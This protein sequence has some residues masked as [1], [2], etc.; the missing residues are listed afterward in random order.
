MASASS[1]SA[2]TSRTK[3]NNKV[4]FIAAAPIILLIMTMFT[5]RFALPSEEIP[6]APRLRHAPLPPAIIADAATQKAIQATASGQI[7]AIGRDDF[8]AALTFAVPEFAAQTNPTKFGQ[9][10]RQGFAPLH[11]AKHI[12]MQKAQ[13]FGGKTETSANIAVTVQDASGQKQGYR[14]S[15]QKSGDKWLITGCAPT[16][17][18]SSPSRVSAGER[19]ARI[20]ADIARRTE[21]MS[22]VQEGPNLPPDRP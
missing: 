12:V 15:L 6:H 18:R 20:R 7:N 4:V 8:A 10:V 2:A 17:D 21:V 9:M 5:L 11:T 13:V 16:F 3:A 22:G 14:Y 19:E 1:P